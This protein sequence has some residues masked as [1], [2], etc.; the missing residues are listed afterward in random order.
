VTNTAAG[1]L[2]ESFARLSALTEFPR[3]GLPDPAVRTHVDHHARTVATS[4]EKVRRMP[5]TAILTRPMQ[6]ERLRSE[7]DHV[8]VEVQEHSMIT[9][10][11]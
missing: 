3:V 11:S 2:V 7:R 6:P 9:F 4:S 5:T 8:H 10:E 1:H